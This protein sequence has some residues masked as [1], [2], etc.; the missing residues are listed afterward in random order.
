M[1]SDTGSEED[2]SA[3]AVGYVEVSLFA[4]YFEGRNWPDTGVML[5]NVGLVG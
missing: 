2:D 1:L 3:L 5:E 4:S